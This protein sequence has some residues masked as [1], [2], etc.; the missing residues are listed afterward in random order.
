M[1]STQ[2]IFGPLRDKLG[3]VTRSF[4][5]QRDF[6]DKSILVDLYQS[7]EP[8]GA[9]GGEG[10]PL[11]GTRVEL[12]GKKE[13]DERKEGIDAVEDP[14]EEEEEEEDAEEGEDGGM[15]MGAL[16]SPFRSSLLVVTD[17]RGGSCGRAARLTLLFPRRHL[18]PRT[19]LPLPVQDVDAAQAANVA[20][21][22]SFFCPLL[23]PRP[24][25]ADRVYGSQVMFFAANTPVEQLCTFQY[26]LV[27]LIPG[28]SPPFPPFSASYF[29]TSPIKPHDSHTHRPSLTAL[30]TNLNDAASPLLSTRSK[31]IQKATS[32]KTSDRRSLIR[33]LGLP[34]DVFGAV[35]LPHLPAPPDE[36]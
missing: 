10:S 26:S 23:L 25:P 35:S 30:L 31:R 13:R 21:T 7:F 5:A 9:I 2:P 34:L 3:V 15:Y 4:F 28:S 12:S 29:F 8:A 20:T 22:G 36:Y 18:T 1:L 33:Y 32:L 11:S 24:F 19:R 14:Q 6:D 16:T 17:E 27:A